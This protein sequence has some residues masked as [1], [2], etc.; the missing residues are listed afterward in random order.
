[1]IKIYSFDIFDTLIT[2]KTGTPVGIFLIIQHHLKNDIEKVY[3]INL[4]EDFYQIRIDSENNSRKVSNYEEVTLDDIYDLIQSRFKLTD[5]Q[6]TELKELEIKIELQYSIGIKENIFKVIN[7]LEAGHKVILTSDMYLQ[8]L[9]IKRILES[10]ESRLARCPIYVSSELKVSKQSGNLFKHILK[11][12]RISPDEFSHYGDNIVSDFKVPK[13]LGIKAELFNFGSTT[14]YER[15]YLGEDRLYTQLAAG[16]SKMVRLEL[17]GSQFLERV[18]GCYSGPLLYTY[19]E[20]VLQDAI[21]QNLK[22][23]YFLSR[24]GHILFKI[25]K[26]INKKRQLNLDLRYIH[27]SRQVSYFASLFEITDKECGW[28][29]DFMDTFQQFAERFEFAPEKLLDL[30]NSRMQFEILA[31]TE[32]LTETQ[33]LAICSLLV[34]NIEIKNLF[35]QKAK[36]FRDL[37]LEYMAQNDVFSGVPF[38]MVDMGWSGRMQ[39]S[40]YK[41]LSSRKSNIEINYFYFGTYN[42]GYNKFTRYTTGLNQKK[43]FLATPMKL[44][45]HV[46]FFEAITCTDHGTTLS[47]KKGIDGKID[48]ILDSY[49]ASN[50]WNIDS[51]HNKILDFANFFTDLQYNLPHTR[52]YGLEIAIE[53]GKQAEK[54]IN[55]IAET[56]GD[57]PFTMGHNE[58]NIAILAPKV[59]FREIFLW[60]INRKNGF[61]NWVNGSMRRSKYSVEKVYYFINNTRKGLRWVRHYMMELKNSTR[62][63]IK[64]ILYT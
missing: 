23:V 27:V 64:E 39:D 28:I 45:T 61:S 9:H 40:I 43:Y 34:N 55:E 8:S 51:Y 37:F 59:G 32:K 4:V 22:K 25:G 10:V 57:F 19:T 48:P 56:I 38:G 30:F 24:D 14:E 3:P 17:S 29:K 58:K 31:L 54:P 47:F 63:R 12:Y 35:L 52:N 49:V 16:V 18:A 11:K 50:Q 33:K 15:V 60:A 46:T 53:L 7:L 21:N 2:R 20:F 1:M 44:R 13:R 26:I 62:V 41:V 42:S 5:S 36:D 6:T